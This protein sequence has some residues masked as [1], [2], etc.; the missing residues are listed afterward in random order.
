MNNRQA[1]WMAG[2]IFLVGAPCRAGIP[3]EPFNYFRF[4]DKPAE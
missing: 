3:P 4:N 2:L 1:R